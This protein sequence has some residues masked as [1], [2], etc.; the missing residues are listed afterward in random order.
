MS[1]YENTRCGQSRAKYHLVYMLVDSDVY[2]KTAAVALFQSTKEHPFKARS[3][4]QAKGA[5]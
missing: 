5:L 1:D 2:R 4:N 3:T